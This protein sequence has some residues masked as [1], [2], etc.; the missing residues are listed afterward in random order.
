AAEAFGVLVHPADRA[1]HLLD[2]GK[3]AAAGIVDIGE[4]DDDEMRAGAHERFGQAGIVGGTVGAPRP[5]VNEDNDRRVRLS[6]A[7][8]V[9]LLD[10]GRAV[11]DAHGRADGGTS[12]LAVGDAPLGDLLAIGRVH[13]LIVGVVEALLVRVEPNERTLG[14]RLLRPRGSARRDRRAAR[15][16]CQDRASGGAV[17]VLHGC[18]AFVMV[19]SV[20]SSWLYRAAAATLQAAS[21]TR[22][23]ARIAAPAHGRYGSR[24]MSTQPMDIDMKRSRPR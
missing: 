15:S 7:V 16:G 6:G 8:D 10:P 14:A 23:A 24:G 9:E 20:G 13:D 21:G 17:V 5:A 2:H 11:G 3:E 4:V 18:A 1:A 22:M 19:P 12:P